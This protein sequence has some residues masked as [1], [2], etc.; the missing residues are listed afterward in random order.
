[1]ADERGVPA[2]V[3]KRRSSP[4][5]WLLFLLT[6]ATLGAVLYYGHQLYEVETAAKEKALH[7]RDDWKHKR[8]QAELERVQREDAMKAMESRL[9]DLESEKADLSSVRDS[10]SQEL[11][12]KDSELAKL[13]ATYDSLE[14][15]MKA[16]IRQGEIRLSQANGRIQVDLVDKI[17]FD[18][19]QAVLSARGQEVLQRLGGVL[20]K[21][22][23]RNIQVSGHTDN[24]PISEKLSA[25]F[26]TNWELSVAR[27][28]NVVRY[29]S[30]KGQVPAGRLV[31]AGYGPYHPVATNATPAGR[32]RNRRIEI[33]L[34]PTLQT[35][36]KGVAKQRAAK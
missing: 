8:E 12:E 3:V 19:G 23:D 4:L 6:L 24:S 17:L 22:E 33:L 26:P 25:T 30:E 2:V 11:K 36:H 27:A 32:A 16:E 1:M 35:K 31:A 10:L 20:A 15:K 29:L 7:E 5:P 13:K 28:V 34:T 18:S 9:A 14:D 21:V